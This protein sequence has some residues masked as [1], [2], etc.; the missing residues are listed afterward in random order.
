MDLQD[1]SVYYLNLSPDVNSDHDLPPDS[2]VL[3][4]PADMVAAMVDGMFSGASGPHTG[5]FSPSFHVPLATVPFYLSK[6]CGLL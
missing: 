5:S 3:L 2:Q 4:P 6:T 1:Y